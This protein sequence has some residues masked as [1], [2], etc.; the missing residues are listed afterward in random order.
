[1]RLKHK[2]ILA[3]ILI[4]T[5][6][7][8]S[9]KPELF[10][11]NDTFKIVQFTDLH[12]N[13]R[14]ETSQH[15]YQLINNTISSEKPDLVI[16][17][18]DVV[19]LNNSVKVWDSI[20]CIF[21]NHKT[22]WA[23]V[24]G[25]HEDDFDMKRPEL[26]KL[27]NSY[28]FCL[29]STAKQTTGFSNFTIPIRGSNHKTEALIY[30][31]DSNRYST[32]KKVKGYGWFDITQINWYTR[33]SKKY[34]VQNK[35]K[36]LPSLAFFHIPLIEYQDMIQ[37]K[38]VKLYGIKNEKIASA[39]INSGIFAQFL[40][41]GDIMGTFVG[42]DHNNDFIGVH[43]GIALAYGRYGLSTPC[44]YKNMNAGARVIVLKQGQR[45]FDTWIHS[46]GNIEHKCTY[47]DSFL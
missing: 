6:I 8:F 28:Q 29:N 31:L 41:C 34:T 9:K 15:A 17:T 35:N 39:N 37:S 26:S 12:I 19:M 20:A 1:M 7:V 32:H 5:T 21:E 27:L 11:N 38:D 10:F 42:H 14:A 13:E 16:I 23:V 22:A 4:N 33:T 2:L 44:W 24:Y 46:Q 47:P 25:N 30:C 45:S 40:A 43:H 36:P 18:G 3:I